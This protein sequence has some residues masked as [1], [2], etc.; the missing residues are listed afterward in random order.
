LK[1]L[2]GVRN[3][4]VLSLCRGINKLSLF[5]KGFLYLVSLFL[6]SLLHF[7]TFF[8]L[9]EIKSR[10]EKVY[11]HQDIPFMYISILFSFSWRARQQQKEKISSSSYSS[12]F[13]DLDFQFILSVYND[14]GYV[15]CFPSFR[16]LEKYMSDNK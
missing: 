8:P 2:F 6:Q 7:F 5:S 1:M 15:S 3:K 10:R 16:L 11:I 4:N 14:K 9:F 13:C 12:T